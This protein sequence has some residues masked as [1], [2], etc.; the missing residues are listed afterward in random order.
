MISFLL[1][2]IIV[3]IFL[4]VIGLWLFY[5]YQDKLVFNP[6]DIAEDY[7]FKFNEKFEELFIETDDSKINVI[8]FKLPNPRGVILYCHGN[9]GSLN[10]WGLV[11]EEFSKTGYD[12]VIFDYR[13]YGKSKGR[14]SEKGIHKDVSKIY[15]WL[16]KHYS[17]DKIVVY[18]RSLGT[19]FATKIASR[20][21]PKVLILE[22]PYFNFKSI[23]KSYFP[24]LPITLILKYT[25]RTDKWIRNVNCPVLIFH[26]TEDEVIPYEN[27]VKLKRLL[28]KGDRYVT[29]DYANHNNIPLFPEYLVHLEEYLK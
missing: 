20:N 3:V 2:I 21:N 6:E 23:A 22:T 9:S 17:E 25:I 1:I 26:G 14:K 4:I 12:F 15:E 10:T 28:K 18:G 8:H 19:G 24:Y 27:S 13:G 7:V 29:I 11:G 5:N 16:K